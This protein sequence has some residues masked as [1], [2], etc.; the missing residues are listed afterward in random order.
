MAAI[1]VTSWATTVRASV[2]QGYAESAIFP[3][4]AMDRR[5]HTNQASLVFPKL[6]P[7]FPSNKADGSLL[8]DSTDTEPAVNL[9]LDLPLKMHTY[10]P[11]SALNTE[12]VTIEGDYSERL[13]RDLRAGQ[14]N[15][16][17]AFCLKTA[18]ARS[19]NAG[20]VF[21]QTGVGFTT[22]D[23]QAESAAN[24]VRDILKNFADNEV[25]DSE[26]KYVL[27]SPSIFFDLLRSKMIRS[28]DFTSDSDNSG[29][30]SRI[31]FGDATIMRAVSVFDQDFSSPTTK[32]LL[33]PSKYLA[34]Y[35]GNFGIGWVGNA[36]GTGYVETINTRVSDQPAHEAVL[37]NA[38]V[39]FGT[40]NKLD[41]GFVYVDENVNV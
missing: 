28:R 1:D 26:R 32:L 4:E 35:S 13:G 19:S 25:P 24:V 6:D 37:V 38:R 33:A 15:R 16:F 39:H 27:V 29:Q 20:R 12:S 17:V 11:Y 2:I 8:A 23:Q 34:D 41:E 40:T 7:R 30:L 21:W 31:S 22:D 18:I 14:D 36:F 3:D 5:I 10:I 9:A